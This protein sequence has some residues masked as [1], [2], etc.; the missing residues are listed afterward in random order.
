MGRKATLR[1]DY[2]KNSR[3]IPKQPS[4][5]ARRMGKAPSTIKMRT[6]FQQ[7]GK[8]FGRTSRRG[9]FDIVITNSP[10]GTICS[11]F[12]RKLPDKIRNPIRVFPFASWQEVN[13]KKIGQDRS[14]IIL[15]ICRLADIP[16]ES[17]ALQAIGRERKHLV[18]VEDMPV[19]AISARVPRLN[20]RDSR[21][22]HMARER[23]PAAISAIIKRAIGGMAAGQAENRI[24]DAWIEGNQLVILSPSFMRLHVPLEELRRFLGKDMKS[25]KAF[26]IDEN[27]SYLYWPHADVHFGWEQLQGIVDPVFLLAA[28]RRSFEFN[29]EYGAAIRSLREERGL[30]Q[31]DIQGIADRHLR[32]IENGQISASK[33][34]LEALAEAHE[35]ILADYLD[36]LAKRLQESKTSVSIP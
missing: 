2:P 9:K 14:G 32:R 30:K 8:T 35:M 26:E 23:S 22:L 19:E 29:A 27:G 25:I 13:W 15:L 28:K 24:V 3:T 18:F 11:D 16:E 5:A 12:V 31:T 17:G 1:E 10:Y 21:R 6:V 4:L 20:V 7:I 34:S 36:A 33:S